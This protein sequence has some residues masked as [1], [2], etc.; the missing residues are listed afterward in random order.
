MSQYPPLSR[1]ALPWLAALA[2]L[3]ALVLAVAGPPSATQASVAPNRARAAGASPIDATKVVLLHK[4]VV[5]VDI[6]NLAF[7]PHTVV[8]SPGTKVVWTNQDGFQHTTTSDT[9]KWDSGPINSHGQFTQ[10]FKKAGTY[11]YH[12]TIHPFMHGTIRVKK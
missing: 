6:Q 5:H 7:G 10:V 8:V 11:K 2:A 4:R 3:F 1:R 12:C 9:G